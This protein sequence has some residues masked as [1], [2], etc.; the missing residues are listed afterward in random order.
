MDG[1]IK[2][3]VDAASKSMDKVI[4]HLHK[5]LSTIRTGKATTSMLDRVKVDYYGNPTPINQVGAV[6]TE[7]AR[8]IIVKPWE[9]KLIPAIEKAILAANL[10]VTPQNDGIIVRITV[11]RLTG[12]RRKQYAKDAKK[13]G[14]N[15]K[16]GL[17]KAR[18]DANN[19]FKQAKKNGVSEDAVKK[20]E[21]ELKKVIDDYVKKIEKIYKQKEKE[22]M[23][24]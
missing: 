17:R 18:K 2:R 1:R 3:V 20:G 10:G 11:P 19:A 24:I 9:K 12:E 4:D 8:T 23:T 7:D 21:E 5:E 13:V 22:I 6:S 16:V 14:E 15:A